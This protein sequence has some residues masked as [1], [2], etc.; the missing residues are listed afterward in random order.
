MILWLWLIIELLTGK[1]CSRYMEGYELFG[2]KVLSVNLEGSLPVL[3][4]VKYPTGIGYSMFHEIFRTHKCTENVT[5][6]DKK[7]LKSDHLH[8]CQAMSDVSLP[9]LLM[10]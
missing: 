3:N 7:S 10:L 1:I 6:V 4:F 9:L 8:N 2:L 5:T